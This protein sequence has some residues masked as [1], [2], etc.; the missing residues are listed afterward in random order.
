MASVWKLVERRIPLLLCAWLLVIML[1]ACGDSGTTTTAP[2]AT[3]TPRPPAESVALKEYKGENF[4]INYPKDWGVSASGDQVTFADPVG[5]NLL[6]VFVNANPDSKRSESDLADLTMAQFDGTI[7]SNAQRVSVPTTYEASGITWTQRSATGVLTNNPGVQG[8][9]FL[10]VK[11]Y[12]AKSDKT[13]AYQIEYYGP[14]E[15]FGQANTSFQA[16]LL[17]FKFTS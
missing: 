6:A 13:Y 10:L 7:L 3:S 11:N 4:T 17:S 15:T 16:M 14:A 8:N 12:P 2:S 1:A 9:L 5:K